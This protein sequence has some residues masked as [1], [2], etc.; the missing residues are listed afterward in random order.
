MGF[1]KD[2]NKQ[3]GYIKEPQPAITPGWEPSKYVPSAPKKIIGDSVSVS[4]VYN[5]TPLIGV[6]ISCLKKV[7]PR[8]DVYFDTLRANITLD[9]ALSLSRQLNQAIADA[10]KWEIY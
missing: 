7:E 6:T 4:L 2:T 8:A 5:E 9:Q 10:K 1:F 3:K